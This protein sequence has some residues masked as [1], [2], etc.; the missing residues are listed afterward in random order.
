MSTPGFDDT[1]LGPNQHNGIFSVEGVC[2][3]CGVERDVLYPWA[4][5]WIC[6]LCNRNAMEVKYIGNPDGGSSE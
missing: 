2:P 4:G 6:A 1:P 3:R 5:Q